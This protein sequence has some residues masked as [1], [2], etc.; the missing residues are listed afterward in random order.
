MVGAKPV[1]RAQC[2]TGGRRPDVGASLYS[3]R[4]W[5][6]SPPRTRAGRSPCNPEAGVILHLLSGLERRFGDS[7][8]RAHQSGTGAT[9]LIGTTPNSTMGAKVVGKLAMLAHTTAG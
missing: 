5:C 2:Y 9:L 4:P 1:V 3:A 8:L 6:T 7:R